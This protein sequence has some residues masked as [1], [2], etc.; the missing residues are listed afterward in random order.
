[1]VRCSKVILLLTDANNHYDFICCLFYPFMI[2]YSIL[3]QFTDGYFNE[4]LQSTIG[5]DFKVKIMN[6]TGSDGSL[7]KV[8]ITIWDTGTYIHTYIIYSHYH[9]DIL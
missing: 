4:K 6:V 1:M 2:S 5:V 3:L 9:D 8:K 7:K